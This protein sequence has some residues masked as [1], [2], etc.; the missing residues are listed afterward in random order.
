MVGLL[1]VVAGCHSTLSESRMD[2]IHRE[3][4]RQIDAGSLKP[5]RSKDIGVLAERRPP[6]A[7][8][9]VYGASWCEACHVAARYLER[10]GIP[11]VERDIDE[12]PSASATLQASLAG[13]GL[14][15]TKS[16]PVLDIRGTITVGFFPCIVEAAWSAP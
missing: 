6:G 9:I 12:D 1:L 14:E 15:R 16:L 5:Q 4:Q 8:V 10:R 11:F 2:D 3:C 13:A 7:P